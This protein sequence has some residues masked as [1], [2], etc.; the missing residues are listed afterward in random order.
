[1]TTSQPCTCA[2]CGT[3]DAELTEFNGRFY[4]PVCLDA[5]TLVC[6]DCGTRFLRSRNCSENDAFPVCPDC[7]NRNYTHCTRCGALIHIAPHIY[8][9][10]YALDRPSRFIIC[11]GD[12]VEF[13][14]LVRQNFSPAD[15]GENKAKILAERYAAVFGMEAEY[16]PAFVE[17]LDTLTT[18]IHADGW[19]S[20]YSRCPDVRE[21]VILLGAVDNDKS[22]Q[23]CHKAF[24]KAEN[25][26]YIDSGNG[27]FS[28]QV[29]C[30][31]RR[32][33]RTV[34]KPVGGVF[35]ELLKAQDRF[36]SELSCAEASLAH[37]QSMAANITAA[38]IVVDMVYN[39]LVNGECS[40]RQTDFS[41][42]TVRMSTTLDKNRSAA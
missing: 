19:A 1:M 35:P 23:L 22:R 39:I 14:N 31:V 4:C 2:H 24:L 17:D 8:R 34:R 16:L 20:K 7:Y 40:V 32:N 25:L 37:P 5:L 27:E 38:T 18:L 9:L 30:G 6:T 21:Q 15:L 42:K 29:V 41:T 26:I 10:L 28:G 13:K 11:D 33:G 3:A 36:P 12:K